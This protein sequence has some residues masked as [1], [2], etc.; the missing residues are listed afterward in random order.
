MTG[1]RSADSKHAVNVSSFRGTVRR[2]QPRET[3]A[4]APIRSSPRYHFMLMCDFRFAGYYSPNGR[5]QA[6]HREQDEL[7]NVTS[8]FNLK[9]PMQ[10][11]CDPWDSIWNPIKPKVLFDNAKKDEKTYFFV[12]FFITVN[13]KIAINVNSFCVGFCSSCVLKVFQENKTNILLPDASS[14]S[15]LDLCFE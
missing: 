10:C 15:P 7:A 8:C 1:K 5:G 13:T 2:L 3:R 12:A 14:N 9:Q 11:S 6:R 4:S